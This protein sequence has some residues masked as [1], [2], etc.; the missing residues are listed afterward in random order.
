MSLTRIN[1][2]VSAMNAQRNLGLNT[3]RI[4]VS[5]ERLSSGLRINRAADDPAGLVLSET[6]RAQIS[7]LD[8]VQ[9]NVAEGI[10]LIKTAEGALTEVNALLRQMNDLA[11]DAASNSNNTAETR[12]SLQ[13]QVQSAISTINQ[14]A[15]NT[16]YAGLHLLNGAAGTSTTVLDST[17]VGSA[18][19]TSTNAVA[20]Y[21][22]VDV[23]QAATK[24]TGTG[25]VNVAA[26]IGAGTITLNQVDI[27]FAGTE[28]H[29]QAVDLINAETANTDVVASISGNFI[30]LDQRSYGEANGIIMVDAS[31]VM[32]SATMVQ[33]GVDA[34]GTIDWSDATQTALTAAAG[35]GLTMR[36][37]DGDVVTLTTTGN[38]VATHSNALYIETGELSFQ[39]GLTAS[40]T[41][42]TSIDS[43]AAS[44]LGT[45]GAVS[46][47][48]VST[49]S[50][51][52]SALTI[53]GEAM[54]DVSALRA[55]LGAFQA[56]QLEAQGRSLA[57]AR[58]NLAASES[59]IRDT[60]FGAEMAEFATT[61]ILVQ[62]ATAFLAQ[63]NALPQNI[64]TL[65]R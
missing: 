27:V 55:K 21:A 60:D 18:Q 6:L 1:T 64:L 5:M 24:A 26:G 38:S 57:V 14:I 65:I 32:N 22:D 31:N 36:S 10:N 43:V 29:Q 35:D 53:V 4:G 15:S 48:D 61:Q 2:N 23:T 49:V 16:T 19:A 8:V 28:T 56:N 51:A 58:E 52:Q 13:E 50:G 54:E 25:D 17:N 30:K 45:T 44:Q 41:A 7:G 40:E 63:A 42:S 62:S 9:Q 11:L 39:V 47:I 33:Y 3:A 37:A 46:N 12:A 59:A 20:G 34:V